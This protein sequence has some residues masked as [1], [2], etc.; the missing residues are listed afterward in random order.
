MDKQLEALI[1]LNNSFDV[2]TKAFD[3]DE[4]DTDTY[5]DYSRKYNEILKANFANDPSHGGKLIQKLITDRTGRKQNKWVLRNQVETEQP[6]KTTSEITGKKQDKFSKKELKDFAKKTPLSKLK[7]IVN[8]GIDEHLRIAAQAEIDRRNKEERNEKSVLITPATIRSFDDNTKELKEL[9][10]QYDELVNKLKNN[11][12]KEGAKEL[13]KVQNKMLNKWRNKIVKETANIKGLEL[14]FEDPFIGRWENSAGVANYEPSFNLQFSLKNN[15][16]EAEFEDY[17]KKF[18]EQTSQDAFI[19]EESAGEEIK[20]SEYSPD[21]DKMYYPQIVSEFNDKLTMKERVDLTNELEKAGIKAFSVD[22][23]FFKV[24]II[25]DENLSITEKEEDYEQ[26]HTAVLKAIINAKLGEK[27]GDYHTMPRK[28]RYI[29]ATNEG[30]E[31]QT[32]QYKRSDLSKKEKVAQWYD[33]YKTHDLN[34]YPV[35]VDEKEVEVNEDGSKGNWILMWKDK[36]GKIQYGYPKSFM[37]ENAQKKWDR[38]AKLNDKK[39][40]TIKSLSAKGLTAKDVK[41]KQAAAV[42][43]IIANTGLRVGSRDAFSKTGNRGVTTLAPE[44]VQ[45]KGNKVTLK[46]TGKS[47]KENNNSFED[48]GIATCLNELKKQ[49]EKEGSEFLFPDIDRADVDKIF[50]N[51]FG[52][53][54]MKIK[55]MRTFMAASESKKFLYEISKDFKLTGDVKKDEKLAATKLKELYVHVSSVLNNSPTMAKNSYINP[56]IRSKWLK[57]IGFKG[58]NKKVL[59]AEEIS[60]IN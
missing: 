55:D 18:A 43:G 27:L 53:A 56:A 46:F 15:K 29:A 11:F 52:G 44:N 10:L 34:K 54:G 23:D 30:S 47:Y 40:D 6:K 28:S 26:Q 19:I 41:V 22:G 20:L 60:I 38:T 42:I 58:D 21:E 17:L 25:Q 12:T 2:I 57:D 16:K 45:I 1:L 36:T 9:T 8:E 35:G 4:I 3:N 39:I 5:T 59:K 32:R 50:K 49:A 14:F 48:K 51:K 7:N 31:E 24:S 13:D 37:E 33:K